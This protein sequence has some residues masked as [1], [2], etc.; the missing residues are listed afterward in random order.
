MHILIS[1]HVEADMKTVWNNF[2]E[3]L[4]LALAPK[5]TPFKLLRFDGC[6]VGDEVHLEIGASF[7]AQRWDALIIEQKETEKEIYFIDKGVKLPFF[8]TE[9]QHKHIIKAHPDGTSSIIDDIHF[10]SL[11]LIGW[12][13]YPILWLQFNNRKPIYKAFFSK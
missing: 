8:L 10:K 1:T 3:K 6:H 12:S 7:L 9:W 13:F 5:F 2:N 4:F 11:P